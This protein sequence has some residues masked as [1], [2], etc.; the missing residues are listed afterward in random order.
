M[1][2]ARGSSQEGR[3]RHVS[4]GQ[5]D[6]DVFHL[7]WGPV[8]AALSY[9]FDNSQRQAVVVKAMLGFK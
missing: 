2:L 7:V 6:Q 1:L 3:F 4:N 8:V 5:L 9:I